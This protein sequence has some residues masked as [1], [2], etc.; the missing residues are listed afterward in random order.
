MTGEDPEV[1]GSYSEAGGVGKT[2]TAISMAVSYAKEYPDEEVI[3]G[4]LDPRSA[5]SKWT[6]VKPSEPGMS[7]GAI[8]GNE[9]VEGWADALAIPL[10]PSKG[11]P[12]N[13]RV[14]PSE[15]SLATHE[16][17]PDDHAELRLKRSLVGTRASLVVFDF[18]NRQGGILT[19]NGLNACKRIVYS[20]KPNE[21]GLDGVD[22]AKMTVR[23]F[24][25]H[26]KDAGIAG[27]LPREVGI[28]L[29]AAYKGAVWTRDALRVVREFERTS[30]GMLLTPYVED[31]GIIQECKAAGEFYDG[32]E[33]GKRVFAA[34]RELTLKKVL[35]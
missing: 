12:E 27:D 28:A 29:A 30:P 14:I 26:R 24:K 13:L 22:G 16:K 9:D 5:A 20:A 4:D 31:L 33:K 6:G 11:W 2:M 15:R 8:I 35:A 32:Y 21:D 19:L 23:K 18:P 10:D 1:V 17:S 7:M 25:K 3:L 34:Y